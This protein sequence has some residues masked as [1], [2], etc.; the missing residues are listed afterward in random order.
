MEIIK[1]QTS[2]LDAK[3]EEI[4]KTIY[5]LEVAGTDFFH[6]DVM[7]GKFV[8]NNTEDIMKEYIGYIKQVSNLPIDVHL[9]VSDVNTFVKEYL[10]FE[11]NQIIFHIEALKNENDILKQVKYIKDNNCKVGLSINPKTS[12][13]KIYK[14]LPYIHSVLVMSVE[15]GKGG[16]GFIEDVVQKI[17]DLNKFIYDNGF[18]VD[19][20]I[21]GG[22]ND[23]SVKKVVDAGA[24]I[25]VSGNYILKSDNFEEAI[26][27]L[28]K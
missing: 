15:P 28:K 2:L 11:P 25:V 23:K 17:Q 10:D 4:I 3:K 9:M 21:D 6:I 14:Y 27:S 7:D 13:D 26:K 19:I 8:E 24:N 12:I 20:I 1:V 22:I 18:D 5:N 16:Q